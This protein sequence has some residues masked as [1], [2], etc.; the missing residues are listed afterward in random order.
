MEIH[1]K[2]SAIDVSGLGG[3]WLYLIRGQKTAIIDTGPKKPLPIPSSQ[4]E[5]LDNNVAPVLQFLPPVLAKLGMTL[6][7]IYLIL[8]THIHFDHTA[9][10]AAIKN[11]SNA[12]ILIHSDE[13][14]YFEK[15][16]RLFEREQAPI[17]E[18]ILGKEHIDEEMKHFM[19]EFTGPGPYAGVDRRLEDNDI[20]ELG[21]GLDLKV[22]HLPGHTPGSIGFYWE[23][24]GLL[25]A[26]D[27]MQGVCGHDG[28]LP[29]IDD[30]A[31][32]E[33]SL[34]RVQQMPLK[35]LVHSHPFRGLSTP[36]SNLMRNGEI[37]QFLEECGEFA[38]RLREAANLVT[39]DFSKKRFL[40][41]YVE[42]ALSF[43]KE[44]GFKPSGEMLRQFFSAA[45]LLTCIKEND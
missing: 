44:V 26:G 43:P 28:G 31:A 24:E 23:E 15:P 20:I 16:E 7:D 36:P 32:Y 2:V 41:L 18:I 27:A 34:E 17:I 21:E 39:P 38:Q 29:I 11:A 33:K 22:I 6:A 37:K 14:H 35:V 8:N 1:P 40:E 42:V 3:I 12:Q 5:N 30:L 10:N 19:N 45:T 13:A 25:F 4:I 9:G